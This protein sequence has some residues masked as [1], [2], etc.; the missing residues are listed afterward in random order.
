[1]LTLG[2]DDGE[3]CRVS[4]PPVIEHIVIESNNDGRSWPIAIGFV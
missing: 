4:G 2:A 3:D 1:M